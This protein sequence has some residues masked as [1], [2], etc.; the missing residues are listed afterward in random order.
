V[1][2]LSSFRHYFMYGIILT[3]LVG[4]S[5]WYLMENYYPQYASNYLY[6]GIGVLL[7]AVFA[8]MAEPIARRFG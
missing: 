8:N 1:N 4:G 5:F 2:I 7:F 3:A 6:L